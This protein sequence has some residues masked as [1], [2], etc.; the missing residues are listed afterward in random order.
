MRNS[1]IVVVFF[2][3]MFVNIIISNMAYSE[4]NSMAEIPFD[5]KFVESDHG[6]YLLSENGR[7]VI[8]GKMYDLWTGKEIKTITDL[9]KLSKVDLREMGVNL[10]NWS[11]PVINDVNNKSEVIVFLDIANIKESRQIIDYIKDNIHQ[12][13]LYVFPLTSK[14]SG[15][16]YLKNIYCAGVEERAKT[17]EDLLIGKQIKESDCSVETYLKIKDIVQLIQVKKLPA[18]ITRDHKLVYSMAEIFEK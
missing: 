1:Q 18:F 2:F 10:E 13:N 16:D 4:I 5:M 17:L 8:K 12:T 7:F 3:V 14:E 6:N 15:L 9:Q 11:V